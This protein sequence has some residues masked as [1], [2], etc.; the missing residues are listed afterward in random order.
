MQIELHRVA[1]ANIRRVSQQI[2]AAAGHHVQNVECFS[3]LFDQ[4]KNPGAIGPI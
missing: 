3:L 2:E 4:K 1:K